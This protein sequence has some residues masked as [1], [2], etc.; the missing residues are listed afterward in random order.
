MSFS[1]LQMMGNIAT[2]PQKK[3]TATGKACASFLLI[4]NVKKD[5]KVPMWVTVWGYGV[6]VACEAGKGA[7]VYVDGVLEA[8]QKTDDDPY[9]YNLSASRIEFPRQPGTYEKK[10]YKNDT[11]KTKGTK[12]E[13]DLPF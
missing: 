1:N 12:K 4:A 3:E 5:K 9:Q 11:Q 2:N 8:W 7:L 13:D 10:E 6:D